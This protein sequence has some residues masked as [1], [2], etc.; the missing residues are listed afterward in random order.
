[1]QRRDCNKLFINLFATIDFEKLII[2]LTQSDRQIEFILNT[3]NFKKNKSVKYNSHKTNKIGEK[4]NC[5]KKA[6]LIINL[7]LLAIMGS[8]V[9]RVANTQEEVVFKLGTTTSITFNPL[10]GYQYFIYR[11]VLWTPLYL[12]NETWNTEPWAAEY[13]KRIDP[14]TWEIKLRDNLYWHD[15]EPVKSEDYKFTWELLIK[16]PT[17]QT[18]FVKAIDNIEIINDKIFRVHL[19]YPMGGQTPF[20]TG[21]N[22]PVPKHIWEPK[23]LTDESALAYDNI[24]PVGNGPFKFVEYKPGDYVIFEAFD[25]FFAGRPKIDRLVIKI[26]SSTEAMIA[27]LRTGE[28]DA[29]DMLPS[30]AAL[31]LTKDPNIIVY[32]APTPGYN[33]IYINQYPKPKDGHPALDDVTVRQAIS[34]CIDKNTINKAVHASWDIGWSPIPPFWPEFNPDAKEIW[35]KFDPEAAASLLEKAGYKDTNNDGLREDPATGLPLKFR[36]YVYSGYPDELRAAEL[37]RETFREAG[38]DLEIR[39]MEAVVWNIVVSA[40]YDWDMVLWGWSVFDPISC[41]YPYTTEAIDAGWSSSG[42]HNQTFDELYESLL[43]APDYEQYLNIQHKL[44]EHFVQNIIEIVLYHHAFASAWRSEWTGI[45]RDPACLQW[46][47]TV[48]P[49]ALLYVEKVTAPSP[50]PLLSMEQWILIITIVVVCTVIGVG[51][52]VL[53]KKR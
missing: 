2:T 9:I 36:L 14:L 37:M 38:M 18:R 42:Y 13:A 10:T 11:S 25:K 20:L 35:P 15:G 5:L 29:A 30:T 34:M 19:K 39:A 26:F 49:K 17:S 22:V 43:N 48:N 23:G 45:V 41:W 7:L 46:E 53:K 52:W 27:A 6:F 3:V 32:S 31:E 12:I 1:M 51:A 40:P 33:G 47:G 28:I 4:M 44:Q 50:Q 24:P 21:C 16:Y 8:N